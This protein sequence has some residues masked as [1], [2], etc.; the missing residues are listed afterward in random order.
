MR[1]LPFLALLTIA[2]EDPITVDTLTDVGT[3][4]VEGDEVTVDFNTCLSSS[5]DTLTSA[6]C[7]ATLAGDTV[8]VT[9]EAVITSQGNECTA[10][11]GLVTV[12]CALPD[13]AGVT[14]AK[15][16]YAGETTNVADATCEAF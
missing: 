16:V 11:C 2:C 3:V 15:I 7:T 5:C 4:C 12:S 1:T 9:A 13:L 14:D 8:T 10:D 6:E